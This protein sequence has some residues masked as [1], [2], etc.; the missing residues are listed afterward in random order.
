MLAPFSPARPCL[1]ESNFPIAV[2]P[3]DALTLLSSARHPIWPAVLCAA[4]QI[5][6]VS[7]I[8]L[9]QLRLIFRFKPC[10][11]AIQLQS[12]LS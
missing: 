7:S 10:V 11:L 3:C 1:P 4:Q 12:A 8:P 6:D 5:V 9:L 2:P